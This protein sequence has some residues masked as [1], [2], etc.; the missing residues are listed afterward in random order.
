[1]EKQ[2]QQTKLQSHHL[3]ISK[4]Y[5]LPTQHVHWEFARGS[6]LIVNISE[7]SVTRVPLE[8][9]PSR[10]WRW[11]TLGQFGIVPRE[12]LLLIPLGR[13]GDGV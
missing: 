1:M 11:M 8:S 3:K 10:W 2:Q 7:P 12:S 9:L 6:V 13:D 4:V 5:F